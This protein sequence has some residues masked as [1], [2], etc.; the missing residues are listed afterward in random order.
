MTAIKPTEQSMLFCFDK[1]DIRIMYKVSPWRNNPKKNDEKK[2][3]MIVE[4][5]VYSTSNG[6]ST[7][8][9]RYIKSFFIPTEWDL[10]EVRKYA[11]K[12]VNYFFTKEL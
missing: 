9:P 11:Q 5:F 6:N 12:D 3:D 10:R 8:I 2:N 4:R 1:E 7:H